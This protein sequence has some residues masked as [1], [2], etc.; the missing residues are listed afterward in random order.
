MKIKCHTNHFLK[1]GLSIATK[2]SNKNTDGPLK[3]E[4]FLETVRN[5]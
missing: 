1:R 5:L 4:E 2:E 3:R